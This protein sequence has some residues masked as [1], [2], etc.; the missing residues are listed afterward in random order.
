[1]YSEFSPGIKPTTANMERFN[2]EL[3]T[4]AMWNVPF[5]TVLEVTNL[6]NGKKI[7]VR[8]NDRGPAKRYYRRGRIIDLT[9]GA[10]RSIEDPEK[11]LAN[12][13]VRI[14]GRVNKTS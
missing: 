5:N 3:M 4:C 11:G 13:K 12:V 2:D 8:V 14:V 1:W 9:L 6:D 10:F 7:I